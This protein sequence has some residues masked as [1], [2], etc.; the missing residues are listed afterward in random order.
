MDYF[1]CFSPA[2]GGAGRTLPLDAGVFALPNASSDVGP[3]SIV[4][5][6]IILSLA[7]LS[8]DILPF[9]VVSGALEP[10]RSVRDPPLL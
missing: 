6:F 1:S 7:I 9:E 8:F 3:W 2:F 4:P 10:A 5:D